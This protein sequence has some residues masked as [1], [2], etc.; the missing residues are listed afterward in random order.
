[1]FELKGNFRTVL[2]L[3]LQSHVQRRQQQ[4]HED[5]NNQGT[6]QEYQQQHMHHSQQQQ[7]HQ[8]RVPASTKYV[9]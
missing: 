6:Q 2:E 3:H 5:L 9:N 7:Q 4:R 8:W 1:M